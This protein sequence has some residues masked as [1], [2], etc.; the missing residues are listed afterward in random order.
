VKLV[1][2]LF[3]AVSAIKLW[4]LLADYSDSAMVR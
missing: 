3:V 2:A 4:P 1:I